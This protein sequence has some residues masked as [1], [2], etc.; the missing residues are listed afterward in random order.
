[1]L[2]DLSPE[3]VPQ[4]LNEELLNKLNRAMFEYHVVK[5]ELVCPNCNRVYPI[6]NSIPNML[7]T[8]EPFIEENN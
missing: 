6:V 7:I 8:D 4:M 2:F 1:M 5:G 3:T